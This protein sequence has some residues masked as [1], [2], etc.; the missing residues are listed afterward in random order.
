MSGKH[1]AA[2]ANIVPLNTH[3]RCET[4]REVPMQPTEL[5]LN[6]AAGRTDD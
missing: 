6:P 2:G 4:K 3:A 1:A 5:I